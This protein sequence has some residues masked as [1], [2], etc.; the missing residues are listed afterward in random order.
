YI[1]LGHLHGG[2]QCPVLLRPSVVVREC[3]RGV[4]EEQEENILWLRL[5]RRRV[6][7]AWKSFQTAAVASFTFVETA[8][9]LFAGKIIS[10]SLRLTRPVHDPNTDGM[11]EAVLPRLGP[12]IDPG[13][14]ADR[15]VGFALTERADMAEAVLRRITFT[16]C[17]ARCVLMTGHGSTTVNNPYASSLD[18][19]A[20]GGYTGEANARVAAMVLNDAEVRAE[21]RKRGIDIP[22]DTW[23][24]GCLH[25]TTTDL[26]TIYDL[27]QAPETHRE[28]IA[29]IQ[30]MLLAAGARTRRERAVK[31]GIDPNSDVDR[32][33]FARSRDWS[34][35]RPEWGNAGNAA[36]IAAPRQRTRDVD[37]GGRVFLHT[38]DLQ[39]DPGFETLE[40]V[41]TAPMVVATWLNLQ[42]FGSTVNNR[43][44]GSGNK[45]LH[46]VAGILG[47]LEGNGGDLQVGLP[48]Q[49]VHDGN[50]FIHEPLRLNVLIEAPTEAMNA[51]I[52]KHEAVR[53]LVDNRWI[54]L[55]AMQDGRI[56]QRYRGN[57][58]WESV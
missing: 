1:P 58:T 53:Q 14:L 40:L 18:C 9:L 13:L 37:L 10:D 39:E 15:I 49:S 11:D 52:A 33:I 7:K 46:N 57:G 2:A 27:D 34:Q 26:V 28:E 23:F 19:A 56:A 6:A 54:H 48:W 41:M 31:L 21:L 45:V 5:L 55:F 16:S 3:V 43:V 22:D 24:F 42:Y 32:Q 20:C 38:Y 29:R 25:D 30:G 36:F 8:G 47:V 4:S 51:V 17:F 35:V 12:Q 50:R 44:F